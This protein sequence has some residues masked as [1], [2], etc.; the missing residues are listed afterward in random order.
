MTCAVFLR[1]TMAHQLLKLKFQVA[2]LLLFCHR[3]HVATMC[4]VEATTSADIIPKFQAF[5]TTARELDR[6]QKIKYFGCT[7]VPG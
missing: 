2:K 4:S 6:S 1:F 5:L 7:E 3:W